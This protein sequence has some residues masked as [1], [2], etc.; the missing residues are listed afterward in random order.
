MS[1]TAPY[2]V[3][4]KKTIQVIYLKMV[5]ITCLTNGLHRVVEKIKMDFLEINS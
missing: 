4:V 3:M 2:M 1:N 5:R